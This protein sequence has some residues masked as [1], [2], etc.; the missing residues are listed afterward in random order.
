[1][2]HED[3]LNLFRSGPVPAVVLRNALPA[4]LAM[5]MVLVYNLADTFFLGLLH[6]PL[7]VAAVSL[8]T[9]VFLLFSD[10]G[11]LFGTGGMSV[12]SRALGRG[13]RDMARRT[14]AFCFWA[15]LASGAVLGVL[16]L[17]LRSLVLPLVGASGDT[18]GPTSTYLEIVA[19]GGPFT[20]AATCFSSILRA[21]G[22]AGRAMA[23][24]VLGNVL[25]VILDPLFILLLHWGVAGAAL[26]T[27]L[28]NAAGT[29]CGLFCLLGGR[30]SLSIHL[31]DVPRNGSG[32]RNVLANGIPAALGSVLI[33]VAQIL[34]NAHVAACSDLAVAA[35]GV[36]SRIMLLPVMLSM[37]L[38]QSVQ[39][40][41]GYCAGATLWDRFR[42]I[43]RFSICFALSLGIVLTG[44]CFLG[45]HILVGAFLTD[46]TAFESSVRFS[47]ILL[48]SGLTIG[49]YFVLI[50]TLQALGCAREALI[51]NA[52]RQGQFFLP[53]ILLLEAA[54]GLDGVIWAQPVTDL[55]SLALALVLVRQVLGRQTGQPA[56]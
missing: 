23:G 32:I 15:S 9:P 54:A 33:S 28:G 13:D 25:N 44:A 49:V 2:K 41:L 24:Q 3:S 55:F 50:H 42:S 10:L 31:R 43:F 27:V 48:T 11:T 18:W 30:S 29:F 7:L 51:L 16:L 22:Q 56:S 45:L 34:V 47:G 4:M 35:M 53:A 12:I 37:G 38:G 21:E 40:L 39:P 8:A 20:V 26:A 17:C 36:A 6:D 14:G 1:M 19:L 46:P 52:G 5:L